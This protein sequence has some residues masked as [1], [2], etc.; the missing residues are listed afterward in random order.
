MKV[1]YVTPYYNGDL[2]GR[3]GRFHDWVHALRDAT[4]PPFEFDVHAL[5]ATDA[6]DELASRPNDLLGD[7]A[8]LWGTKRNKLAFLHNLPRLRSDLQSRDYDVVHVIHLDAFAYPTAASAAGD[9]SIVLGP[10]IGGWTPSREGG[11]WDPPTYR[12]RLKKRLAFKFRQL[13]AHYGRYDAALAFSDYHRDLLREIGVAG[14]VELLHPGVD[15]M[16]HP[17]EREPGDTPTLLYVGDLSEHKGYELFLHALALA[18][19]DLT[20]LVAGTGTP[21]TDL[22]ES[23]GLA[24]IVTHLGFVDRADLPEYYNWADLHVVP[25]VDEMGPN[26]QVEALA[27]GTPVVATDAPG[28]NEYPP[29]DAAVFFAPRRPEALADALEQAVDD[30]P[31]LTECA[32]EYAP[33]FTATETVTALHSFY[34]SMLDA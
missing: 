27:C 3:F 5:T 20:A 14:D 6:G 10:N 29:A 34:E 12:G 18:D 9:A 7:G 31:A 21:R 24:D 15:A 23:L 22:V 4:D 8:D 25:S 16:F 32:R 28:I 2:D 1:A 30:L 13:L 33:S 17:D 19:R 26:T 11:V